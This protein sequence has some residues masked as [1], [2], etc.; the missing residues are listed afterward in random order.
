MTLMVK[1]LHSTAHTRFCDA[2][3]DKSCHSA[4]KKPSKWSR[5]RRIDNQFA[6]KHSK[7]CGQYWPGIETEHTTTQKLFFYEIK[8]E[9]LPIGKPKA[10]TNPKPQ[11]SLRILSAVA[12]KSN[13]N[14]TPTGTQAHGPTLLLDITIK[15]MTSE[16]SVNTNPLQ[17]RLRVYKQNLVETRCCS[18]K[19]RRKKK[20]KKK[21][22]AEE[23]KEHLM[24]VVILTNPNQD[25]KSPQTQSKHQTR[26]HV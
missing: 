25:S 14:Q 22:K 16:S 13:P 7:G 23:G 15:R 18:Q 3:F 10:E 21:K 24:A 6:R 8:S 26:P 4:Y 17:N 12:C 11:D 1:N 2:T 5:M 20:K 19:K 9:R